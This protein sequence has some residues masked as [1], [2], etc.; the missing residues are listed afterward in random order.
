MQEFHYVY[1]IDFLEVPHVYFG[2][3]TSKCL[4]A[5]DTKY[6]GSPKTYKHYWKDYTPVKTIL[7][8]GF[9]NREDAIICEND[10]IRQQWNDNISISL[11]D[12]I[13]WTTFHRAGKSSWNKGKSPSIETRQ[14]QSEA[15]KGEKHPFYGKSRP[16]EVTK[17][18]S[19]A[20]KGKIQTQKNVYR[21]IPYG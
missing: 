18:I 19:D 2:S 21:Y 5:R 13:G 16:I 10:L 8:T 17:R 1:R 20:R 11:N 7:F 14:K 6:M 12:H 3:R 4:P 15:K 9:E